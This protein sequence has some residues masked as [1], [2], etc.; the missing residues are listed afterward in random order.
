MLGKE[1][2]KEKRKRKNRKMR[3]IFGKEREGREVRF[4]V[5]KF[6]FFPLIS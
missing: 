4:R 6:S 5:I 3:A 2:E 1:K